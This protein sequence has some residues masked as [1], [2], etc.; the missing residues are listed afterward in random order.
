MT[1]SF[2][3]VLSDEMDR[4]IAA[5]AADLEAKSLLIRK[6]LI[7]YLASR[8]AQRERGLRLGLFDPNTREIQQE[9]IGL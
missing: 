4:Q 5:L 9:I 7:L 6:A 2:N 8:T 1:A 3:L